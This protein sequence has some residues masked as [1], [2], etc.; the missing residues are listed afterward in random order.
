MKPLITALVVAVITI[1]ATAARAAKTTLVVAAYPSIDQILK[2]AVPHWKKL[3]PDVD[4]KIVGREFSD[5]HSSMITA[6]ATN[7]GL[8]DVMAVEIQFIGRFIEGGGLEDLSQAPYRA[9]QHKNKII[10]Y[11]WAQATSDTGTLG[12]IPTDVGPGTLLYRKDIIEAAGL[13]E[14]DLT[15]SWESYIESG[16]KLKEKTGAYIVSNAR[17]V[18]DLIIRVNLP[19]GEGIYFDK[20]HNVLIDNERFV[21]AFTIARRF[22]T[23]RS[24]P[25]WAPGAQNGVRLSNAALSR[26]KCAAHG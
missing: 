4:I 20:N 24:T 5:H 9:L 18:K 25:R 11:A 17:D 21:R 19:P 13:T 26:R 22:V 12:A 15:R 16:K 7:S 14:S 2:E 10:P 23:L 3:H 1:N 8:P 6:L